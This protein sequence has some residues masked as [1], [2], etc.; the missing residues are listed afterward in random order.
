[1]NQSIAEPNSDLNEAHGANLRPGSPGAKRTPGTLP[2]RDYIILPL[3]SLLTLGSMFAAAELAARIVAPEGGKDACLA[4][5]PVAGPHRIPNC[6][7]RMKQPESPWVQYKYN[8]CGYRTLASCGP[9]RAGT[10][11]LVLMGASFSEG[12]LVPYSDMFTTRASEALTRACHRPVE[13]QDMGVEGCAPEYA[14]RRVKEALALKPDVVILALNA[15][16]IEHDV[17]PTRPRAPV[18][19]N[20]TGGSWISRLSRKFVGETQDL[21]HAS[22]AVLVAQHLLLQNVKLYIDGYL[23]Q[24]DHAAF[25]RT[26]FS[27]VW[28]KRFANLDAELGRMAD[29]LHAAGVPFVVIPIPER[30]QAALLSLRHFP[31]GVDPFAFDHKI[32]QIAARHGIVYMNVI[33]N[34]AR[35]PNPEKLFYVVDSHLAP[36]GDMLIGRTI[37]QRFLDSGMPVFASCGS[38]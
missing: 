19:P 30:S 13:I 12:Y 37:A 16:D 25:L 33:D 28:D 26:N 38:K 1:M 24:G 18:L 29:Q 6:E 22:R 34:F 15:Y 14:S 5:D 3:L 4:I 36:G 8:A 11:R 23:L 31:P 32:A 9:K 17:D 35:V 27:P 7:F 21:V 2:K 20:E 10:I